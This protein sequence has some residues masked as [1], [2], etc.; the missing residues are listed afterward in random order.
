MHGTIIASALTALTIASAGCGTT[1]DPPHVSDPPSTTGVELASTPRNSTLRP[2]PTTTT[3]P[4]AGSRSRQD[5]E[6]LLAPLWFGWYA[7]VAAGDIV[8]LGE[9]VAL[10]RIHADGVTAIEESILAFS[11]PPAIDAYEFEVTDVLRDSEDCLV[12]SLRENPAAFLQGGNEAERIGVFWP[13][14]GRW[15]LATSWIAGTPE[16]AWADD[17]ELM[18]REFA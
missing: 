11:S 14:E 9:T 10:S 18:V 4:G 1:V 5:A 7:A 3:P 16:F 2:A 17:C 8:A 13:H 12:A 6:A 15:Y